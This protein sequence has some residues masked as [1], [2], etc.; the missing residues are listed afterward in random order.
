MEQTQLIRHLAQ[1][2]EVA[3]SRNA[4]KF[5]LIKARMDRIE[6]RL[7]LLE[8]RLTELGEQQLESEVNSPGITVRKSKARR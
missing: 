2:V 7:A 6:G 3:T 5:T 4:K 1:Q 8:E